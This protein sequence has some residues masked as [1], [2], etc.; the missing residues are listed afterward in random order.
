ME[1]TE[2]KNDPLIVSKEAIEKAIPVPT[3]AER[4]FLVVTEEV[5]TAEEDVGGNFTD[6]IGTHNTKADSIISRTIKGITK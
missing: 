2:E 6:Q 5:E 1:G 4:H 3:V